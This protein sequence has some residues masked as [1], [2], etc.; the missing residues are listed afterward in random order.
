MWPNSST[1]R[2]FNPH[3][4][5][6]TMCPKKQKT[7]KSETAWL[8]Q[9][10]PLK[11]DLITSVEKVM[12]FLWNMPEL[13]S[14]YRHFTRQIAFS[15]NL[16]VPILPDFWHPNFLC[17]PVLR[18]TQTRTNIEALKKLNRKNVSFISWFRIFLAPIFPLK[19][20]IYPS[21]QFEVVPIVRLTSSREI[22]LPSSVWPAWGHCRYYDL[23]HCL[24]CQN[25]SIYCAQVENQQ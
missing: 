14:Q 8:V 15:T 2:P 24:V 16:V 19:T 7:S 1:F 13:F 20:A 22:S 23:L 4:Q 5:N 10:V 11:S 17:F 12:I 9:N 3:W 21:K 18:W 6:T 25:V